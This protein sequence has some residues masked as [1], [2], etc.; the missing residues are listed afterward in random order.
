MNHSKYHSEF[1]N[2]LILALGSEPGQRAFPRRVGLATPI[3]STRKVYFGIEGEA[4]IQGFTALKV[5]GGVFAIGWA[6]EVKTGSG[7]LSEVQRNWKAMFMSLGGRYVEARWDY[8]H[9]SIEAA[10]EKTRQA[11]RIAIH[12]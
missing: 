12:S 2:A 8:A 7:R 9:E 1:V 6:V 3:G 11:L 4:D 5:T 10:A